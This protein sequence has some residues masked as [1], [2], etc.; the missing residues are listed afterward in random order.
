MSMHTVSAFTDGLVMLPF[1]LHNVKV[2]QCG[3]V[4]SDLSASGW[5]ATFIMAVLFCIASKGRIEAS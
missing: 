4:S 3:L 1:C 5:L 2:L